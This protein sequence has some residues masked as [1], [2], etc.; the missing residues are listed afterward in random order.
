MLSSLLCRFQTLVLIILCPLLGYGVG[1]YLTMRAQLAQY[2]EQKKAWVAAME[3][4]QKQFLEDEEKK[5]AFEQRVKALENELNQS[6]AKHN[7][8]LNTTLVDRLRGL[9]DE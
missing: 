8:C 4:Q 6:T 7:L 5:S 3:Q 1:H 2:Q 9:W